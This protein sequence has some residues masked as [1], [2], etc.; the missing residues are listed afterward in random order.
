MDK[1]ELNPFGFFGY[2]LRFPLTLN[3]I[4]SPRIILD[5]HAILCNLCLT[6]FILFSEQC[7]DITYQECKEMPKPLECKTSTLRVPFQPKIHRVKCLL[8]DNN[9]APALD[10][11]ESARAAEEKL[12]EPNEVQA[13]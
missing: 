12:D 11:E 13:Q 3:G 7:V 10:V 6:S 8:R 4:P 5:L 2:S 9:E 1:D